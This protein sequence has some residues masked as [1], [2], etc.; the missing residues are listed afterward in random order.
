MVIM[1]SYLLGS[2]YT[3]QAYY[4]LLG[5]I[6]LITGIRLTSHLILEDVKSSTRVRIRII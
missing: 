5:I 1:L 2:E 6:T 4:Q 3:S